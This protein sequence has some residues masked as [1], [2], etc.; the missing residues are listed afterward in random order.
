MSDARARTLIF[1]RSRAALVESVAA[2]AAA[3]TRAP[4]KWRERA[5]VYITCVCAGYTPW[6]YVDGGMDGGNTVGRV[7]CGDLVAGE[8]ARCVVGRV[9]GEGLKFG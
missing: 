5:C 1:L 4:T 9:W 2:A 6:V 8:V 3:A 7:V